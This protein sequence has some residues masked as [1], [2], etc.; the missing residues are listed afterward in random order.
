MRKIFL[1]FL[2]FLAFLGLAPVFG[3]GQDQVSQPPELI[4]PSPNKL[5]SQV[6]LKMKDAR[7]VSGL[8][9]G[10]EG[11]AIVLRTG[12]GRSQF[13]LKEL[14][15]VTFAIEK[16]NGPL[17]VGGLF[18]GLYLGNF[19]FDA[20]SQQPIR[21]M[22]SSALNLGT[23]LKNGLYLSAGFGL[24]YLVE[25]LTAERELV[26]DFSG[27]QGSRSAVWDDLRRYVVDEAVSR[28][29]RFHV[30]VQAAGVSRRVSK[31]YQDLFAGAGYYVDQYSWPRASDINLLR[32]AQLTFSLTSRVETGAAVVFLG[33]RPAYAW[34]YDRSISDINQKLSGQGYYLVGSFKPL[35]GVLPKNVYW[36]L[37]LGLGAAHINFQVSAF[38]NSGFPDYESVERGVSISKTYASGLVFTELDVFFYRTTSLGLSADYVFIPSVEAAA[39]PEAGIPAHRLPLGR[40]TF[41]LNLGFHF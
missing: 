36:S 19:I 31:D 3:Q 11:D 24:G 33:E 41:G 26:F 30:S 27:D 6:L 16:K 39:I 18:L 1:I 22:Q 7:L 15:R 23:I 20:D 14:V 10:L 37:G 13:P 40:V 25:E 8:L 32:K 38:G 9:V 2:C 21:F 29:A 4:S 5:F 12:Q 34:N 28:P 17:A 35:L